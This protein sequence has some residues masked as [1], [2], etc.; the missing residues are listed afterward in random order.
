MELLSQ[1]MFVVSAL[2]IMLHLFW[3]RSAVAE[4]VFRCRPVSQRARIP[5]LSLKELDHWVTLET[6]IRGVLTAV[7]RLGHDHFLVNP[8]QFNCHITIRRCT[9]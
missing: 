3:Y 8:F 9:V 2:L 1:G 5:V 7:R 6:R 4:S